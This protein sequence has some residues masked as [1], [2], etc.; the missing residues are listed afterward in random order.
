MDLIGTSYINKRIINRPQPTGRHIYNNDN[1]KVNLKRQ[2]RIAK[3][4]FGDSQ[5]PQ[6]SGI[7]PPF[8]NSNRSK[9]NKVRFAV[10]DS[11]FSDEQDQIQMDYKPDFQKTADQIVSD[12]YDN[13]IQ[14]DSGSFLDQFQ[15][16]TFDQKGSP[17]SSNNSRGANQ[18]EI[19]RKLALDGGWSSF[20]PNTTDMTYGV[21]S[22]EDFTHTN[23]QPSFRS[24]SNGF[25]PIHER[26]QAE[27][28]QRKLEL[29]TGS[30]DNLDYRPKTE[31]KKLF[32][33][34]IGLT[35]LYGTPVM[36]DFLDSRYSGSLGME[37]R[38]EKPFQ[39]VRITPG[40]NLGYN[41]ISK[42]GFH[43]TFRV[44]PK[45]VD[46]LR[47]ANKPKI[48]YG[49]VVIQ[50]Q[51]GKR[52]PISSKVYKRKPLTFRE[53]SQV[54]YLGGKS[55]IT[56]PTVHAKVDPVNMATVNR[57]TEV[58]G[59][60]GGVKFFTDLATPEQ[61]ISKTKDS[62]K[63]N[64]AND[65]E[66]NVAHHEAQQARG[67]DSSY[68]AKIN[69]RNL[70]DKYDRA[71]QVGNSQYAK[72]QAFDFVNAVTDPNMRNIHDKYDR[73]GQLGNSQY[74]KPQA[75]DFVNAVTD[76]NM[77]NIHDKYDRAGQLGNS[78]YAKPQAFDFVNAVTDPNMRNIHDKYDRAGQIG[79][80]QYAKPQAF[81][82]INGTPDANMRN[83]HDKTDRA[84]QVGN[85]QYSKP[86]AF[87]FTNATPDANM[88]TVHARTDRA[89]QMGNS[90]YSKPQ[91]F[92][93]ALAVP[94]ATM[95]NVHDRT[96]RAG[97]VGPTFMEK[98]RSRGDAD[99]M[100]VNDT[101]EIIALGRE[102]TTCNYNK[103]P[104]IDM[105]MVQLKEPLVV[106]RELYPDIKE[107]TTYKFG[108]YYTQNRASLD[109]QSYRFFTFVDE[110]LQGNPYIN[111]VIHRSGEF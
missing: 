31:R 43:D 44:M 80:S 70:H 51:K 91:A 85:S 21:V 14:Q 27:V 22:R 57:G 35:N 53:L 98:Q 64:F 68:D 74:A 8:Y 100:R 11:E 110:N 109:Q 54:D 75:F 20:K 95:R 16:L 88:R 56:A 66:H 105:T 19:E 111:N 6:R 38:N 40:L 23:M 86:Q 94:D 26:K 71:G 49:G 58:T 65:F 93:F 97:F 69:V 89:G 96:D 36:T 73:A 99:N 72:P 79:N 78:Q 60:Y 28:T 7:I 42:Q 18:A 45:T 32:D 103:G 33:P 34:V 10:E 2:E 41:E 62:R 48:S 25:D 87:D 30:A 92:D 63:E 81:D 83:I 5:N 4:R 39:E 102:P 12:R 1:Y 67:H 107:D 77:R 24:R 59:R 101:K 17:L 108:T 52:G 13:N 47:T 50:G 9:K 3:K 61:L 15:Q 104:T 29:F 82:F 37:R 84:G 76:P 55:Y 106:K 46:E 90:E